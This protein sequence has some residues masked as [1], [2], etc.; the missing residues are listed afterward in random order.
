MGVWVPLSVPMFHS[1]SS[2]SRQKLP[3]ILREAFSA[4]LR[5]EIISLPFMLDFACGLRRIHRHSAHG[6]FDLRRA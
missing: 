1:R 4:P 6:V 3:R 5:A 2:R